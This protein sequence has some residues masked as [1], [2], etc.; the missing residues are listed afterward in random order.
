MKRGQIK[1]QS[2]IVT[3]I[4]LI[5]I[6]LAV[7]VSAWEP[8][9][10]LINKSDE[11]DPDII[12]VDLGIVEKSILVDKE[13]KLQLTIKRGNDNGMID[14]IGLIVVGDENYI[15][16]ATDI[17]LPLE[18]RTYVLNIDGN[19]N[20][21]EVIVYPISKKSHGIFNYVKITGNELESI[22]NSL[23]VINRFISK[24]DCIPELECEEWSDCQ[25]Y[26][27]INNLVNEE[28]ILDGRFTRYCIDKRNCFSN[29]IE[30]KECNPGITIILKKINKCS[31]NYLEVYDTENKLLSRL[32]F[33]SGIL[34]IQ[35][36]V[37]KNEHFPYCYNKIQDCD[38]NGVD[39]DTTGI[40][41]PKCSNV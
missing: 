2:N 25:A 29:I 27:D 6:V 33:V 11:I 13:K 26:Y 17:P 15:Y 20:L 10:N 23:P 31:K 39:C 8:I 35:Y 5:L 34:N 41:C 40:I 37:N 30:K 36:L 22:D 19:K 12:F 3:N 32:D 24:N 1:A 7:I 18:L 21:N 28:I 9:S 4:L 38:E 14:S 16:F